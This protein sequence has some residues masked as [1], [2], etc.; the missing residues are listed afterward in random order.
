MPINDK[1]ID[2]SEIAARATL[3]KYTGRTL[4]G[5]EWTT[6]RAGFLEFVKIL[7]SWDK[8]PESIIEDKLEVLCQQ[9]P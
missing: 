1:T 4:T 2:A 5:A 6:M 7:R 8:Q 3:E 9:K